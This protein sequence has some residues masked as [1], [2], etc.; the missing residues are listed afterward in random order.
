MV[1]KK[2]IG[3]CIRT[4]NHNSTKSLT[5]LEDIVSE[6]KNMNKNWFNILKIMIIGIFLLVGVK[7]GGF[8]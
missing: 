8:I 4:L 2:S 5:L 7:L 3:E 6:L 1:T